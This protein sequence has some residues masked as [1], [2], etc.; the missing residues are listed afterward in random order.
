MFHVASRTAFVIDQE[1]YTY[2]QG[3][4]TIISCSLLLIIG[5]RVNRGWRTRSESP[6]GPQQW[7]VSVQQTAGTALQIALLHTCFC[8]LLVNAWALPVC[9]CREVVIRMFFNTNANW[10][11]R[12]SQ[13][14]V[15]H[16]NQA[17]L[18]LSSFYPLSISIFSSVLISFCP[19]C[20]WET[21]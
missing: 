20:D 2:M 11:I 10:G 12:S 8:K 6:I 15:F 3:V 4:K 19:S 13:V 5:C 14:I 17:H 16:L 18:L 7:V 9:R 1:S 21:M